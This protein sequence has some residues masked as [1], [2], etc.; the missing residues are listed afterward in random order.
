MRRTTP[1]ST[2]HLTVRRVP[3]AALAAASALLLAGC[4]SQTV[5]SSSGTAPSPPVSSSA[6]PSATTSGGGC[7]AEVTLTADDNGRT[8]CVTSGGT[9]RLTLDGTTSRPW[10]AVK[11]TGSA[12]E[13]T[14]A[15]ITVAPGDAAS[16][17]HAVA[18]GKAQLSST[19]PLCAQAPGKVSCKGLQ[20]WTAQVTVAAS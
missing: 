20:L 3:L 17:F 8:V 13:A 12:L 18:A 19:R 6:S 4:G 1:H 2:P 14:N 7:S 9:I 15:G 5:G 10:A 11:A 16:A